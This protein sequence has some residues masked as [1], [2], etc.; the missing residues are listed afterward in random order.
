MDETI[1][2]HLDAIGEHL[3]GK[4]NAFLFLMSSPKED[5]EGFN[6]SVSRNGDPSHA[7][8]LVY[9]FLEGNAEVSE[10]FTG[11]IASSLVSENEL[12]PSKM[13]EDAH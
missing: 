5:G 8:G 7:A 12:K 11:I 4:P 2:T 13:N 6:I 1:K 10:C 3:K 9:T